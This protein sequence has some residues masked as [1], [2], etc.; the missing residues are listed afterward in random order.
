MHLRTVL[1]NIFSNWFG[2]AVT[3]GLGFFLA[4]YIVGRLGTSKYGV[5]TLVVSLTG[6]F[7]M[8]DLGIRSSVGRFVARHLARND[9]QSV[10]RTISSA[11]AILGAGGMLALIVS[12][13]L[14]LSFGVF[15]VEPSLESAARSALLI[16][17]LTIGLALP[18]G[19]FGAVLISLERFDVM[20]A[21]NVAGALTRAALTLLVLKLGYGLV[22]LAIIT[23]AVG[24]CEYGA[25]AICA[26]R[27][28]RPLRLSWKT[29]D[30]ASCRELFGFGI[31]R[32]FWIV[33]NQMIFFTDS[34]VIG[35]FLSAGAITYFAIPGSLINYGR[36]IVSLATDALYPVATRLDSK[37]DLSG[38]RELQISGTRLSL[39]IALPLC[40]GYVFLGKQFITLWMGEKYA[41]SAVYLAILAIPQLTSMSQNTSTLILAGMAKHRVL[42]YVALAEGV[43]NLV[44]SIVL[45]RKMGLVGVAWGTVIPHLLT[46]AIIIPLY[47]L[48][49]LRMSP[50]NYLAKAYVRP[51]LCAVPVAAMCFGFATLIERPS[52]FVFGGEVVAVCGLFAI[53]SY[54]ICLNA[55][56]QASL[57]DK[58]RSFLR[59]E[60]IIYEA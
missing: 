22:A 19:V 42:A 20:T 59:S 18:M 26:K 46:T 38:L 28:Y 14:N 43:A 7:G 58:V 6:Y 8:L 4:P 9:D 16:S 57:Q 49:T 53:L 27:L 51:L 48:R 21:V 2:Y 55:V 31:Y 52:W 60:P 33:A 54:Y 39:L 44:L 56:Q 32:F 25:M 10:N 36:N 50:W 47:T 17:G 34:T 29:I 11:F 1:R 23:L 45:V 13:I 24:T 41:V 15:K 30:S 12:I 37:N 40:L 3:I 35:I 5:W